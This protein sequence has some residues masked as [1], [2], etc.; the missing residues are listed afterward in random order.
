M[1]C[2]I[3]DHPLVHNSILKAERIIWDLP[4]LELPCKTDGRVSSN[5]Y[6]DLPLDDCKTT[7]VTLTSDGAV[8]SDGVR[9]VD[10]K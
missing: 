10:R 1:T 4:Y 9:A 2:T 3:C 5:A 8:R 6:C 7:H